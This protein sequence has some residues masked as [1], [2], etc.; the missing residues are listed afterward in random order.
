MLTALISET[1]ILLLVIVLSYKER[2][3]LLNA[4]ISKNYSE[5]KQLEGAPKEEKEKAD[6]EAPQRVYGL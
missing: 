1:L 2:S 5:F 4:V 6:K 3:R